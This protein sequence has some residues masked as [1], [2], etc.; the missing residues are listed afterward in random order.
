[1][2]EQ[3]FEDGDF[4]RA[5]LDAVPLAV[6]VVDGDVSVLGYNQ[7][8]SELLSDT[9]RK[10]IRS[11]AGEILHCV[12]SMVT[13]EGCGGSPECSDCFVRKA[14]ED[15]LRHGKVVRGKARMELFQEGK[16]EHLDEIYLSIT[17][18]PFP[19]RGRRLALLIL[20]DI[21]EL[22]MLKRILPIC[23][24]CKKIRNDDEYWDTVERYFAEHLDL[25]FSHGICPECL[26]RFY[27]EFANKLK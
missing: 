25:A 6:F 16:E 8:A 23:S 26:E 7:A 21:S 1:M 18:A 19:Y 4:V 3:L 11:R 24:H 27:P 17:A 14:V 9:P 10:I 13:P 15:S 2:S 20:Q 12:N 5:I 22:T